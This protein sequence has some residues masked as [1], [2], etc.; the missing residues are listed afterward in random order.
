MDYAHTPDALKVC[1]ENLKGQ[2]PLKKLN[3]VFGCGGERDIPKRKIMGRI[4]NT[5]CNK[6]YLTDDNP[7]REK[8]KKIRNQIKVKINKKKLIEISSREIAIKT[9]IKNIKSD[10]IV[11]VAGKGHETY[12]EYKKKKYFSD[13]D[14][15]L[16]SIKEKNKTLNKNW[17]T[18]ILE[19]HLDNKLNNKI[20]INEACINSKEVKKNN[21]FFGIK[22]N[23]I[24]GN[25]FANEAIKKGASISIIDKN[26]GKKIKNKIKV[27]NTL[28]FFTECAAKIRASSVA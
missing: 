14:C 11:V 5:Y 24:D 15:I 10:E 16:K 3:I 17:K 21:A 18:N 9:A 12:Q 23:K 1:L 27:K 19:E 28:K 7:R 26:Y 4:A 20:I 25:Q 6:I 2:F 13:K 22:G 8:P